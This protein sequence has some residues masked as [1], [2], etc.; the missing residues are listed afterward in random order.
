M[1]KKHYTFV[2]DQ[3]L[4]RQLEICAAIEEKPK[5]QVLQEALEEFF[6]GKSYKSIFSRTNDKVNNSAEVVAKKK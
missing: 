2:I 1:A 4:N 6:N 3:E 5:S